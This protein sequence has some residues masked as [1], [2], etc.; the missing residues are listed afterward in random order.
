MANKHSSAIRTYLNTTYGKVLSENKDGINYEVKYTGDYFMRGIPQRDGTIVYAIFEQSMADSDIIF[1]MGRL[2]Y[3]ELPSSLTEDD[4][5]AIVGT[6]S[7]D[8]NNIVN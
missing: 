3:N 8:E 1:D 5:K 4:A 7:L 6:I 2:T